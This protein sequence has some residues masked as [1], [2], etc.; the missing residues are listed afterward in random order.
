MRGV[1]SVIGLVLG[2]LFSQPL[3]RKQNGRKRNAEIIIIDNYRALGLHVSI[4][5]LRVV[6]KYFLSRKKLENIL[7]VQ[8]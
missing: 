5:I 2:C 4:S 1:D 6:L 8:S 7:I 3:S